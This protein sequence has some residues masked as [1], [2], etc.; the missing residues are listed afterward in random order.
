MPTQMTFNLIACVYAAYL[1]F[2]VVGDGLEGDAQCF[3]M[4]RSAL[5]LYRPL[6][7]NMFWMLTV[8]HKL[9][10]YLQRLRS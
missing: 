10:S 8:R 6:S 5:V 2:W 3:A 4:Y 1:Y 9:S 7:F